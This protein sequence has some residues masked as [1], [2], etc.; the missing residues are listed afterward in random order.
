MRCWLGPQR[1]LSSLVR[2]SDASYGTTS[3]RTPSTSGA[4]PSRDSPTNAQ[5]KARRSVRHPV[6]KRASATY[7]ASTSGPRLASCTSKTNRGLVTPRRRAL[8]PGQPP[9]RSN[10]RRVSRCPK[11]RSPAATLRPVTRLGL[12]ATNPRIYSAGPAMWH[13]DLCSVTAAM[14]SKQTRKCSRTFPWVGPGIARG[15]TKSLLRATRRAAP[16]AWRTCSAPR[17]RR[18]AMVSATM[19]SA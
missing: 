15:C 16:C 10:R 9:A 5:L 14:A 1:P 19:A 13:I 2:P 11:M 6:E 17:G 18:R 8:F 7:S 3:T 4:K 12:A